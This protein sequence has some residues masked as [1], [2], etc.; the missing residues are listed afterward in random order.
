MAT[1]SSSAGPQDAR[2]APPAPAA[3]AAIAS[4]GVAARHDPFVC[5][6]DGPGPTSLVPLLRAALELVER[7]GAL[8]PILSRHVEAV[9]H[10]A[11]HALEAQSDVA[12]LGD[13]LDRALEQFPSE[14]DLS[15]AGATALAREIEAL[16]ARI[17]RDGSAI[18]LGP[19]ALVDLVT[20]VVRQARAPAHAGFV[21]QAA[22][23]AGQITGLLEADRRH[24]PAGRG[25]AAL[26]STF[27]AAGAQ[28]LDAEA[29]ARNLPEHRG[30]KRLEPDR[31]ERLE[32]TLAQLRA[33]V[34][35]TPDGWEPR[36]AEGLAGAIALFDE[37]ARAAL[38][39]LRAM[40][41]ARLEVR[42]EYD[43][44]AHDAPLARLDW[45]GL[46]A[47]ELLVVPPVVVFEE[48][49][50]VRGH[51]LSALSALLLSGR[52]IR[53]IVADPLADADATPAPDTPAGYHPGLGYLAVAHRES[54]V[55]QSTLGRPGHLI[56]GLR[57]MAT[58]HGPAA[59]FVAVP[60]WDS[61]VAPWLQLAAAREGRG[62]PCFAYDPAGGTSWAERF[63]LTDNPEIDRAW[64][65]QTVRYRD[66]SGE[67]RTLEESFTWAHAAALDPSWSAHFRIVPRA[68]WCEEQV[69]V[70]TYLDTPDDARRKLVPF[71]WTVDSE[72]H[73]CRATITRALAFACADRMRAW[74]ILQE[75]A[76]TDNEHVRRAVS[77][78]RDE[79]AAEA[80][81]ERERLESEHAAE[82]ERVRAE[83]A[84]ET[85][86]RLAAVLLGLD[87]LPRAAVDTA[88]QAAL[89]APAA[90]PATAAPQPA[91]AGPVPAEPW[92]DSALCTTCNECTNLNGRMF[93]YNANK[94]AYLADQGAGTF[95]QLVRAAEKCPA[96]C[97]HPGR[98]RPGDKTAN[99]GLLARAAAFG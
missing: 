28:A 52:P 48:A 37:A 1:V 67:E 24:G 88:A 47:E 63:D 60:C 39:A 70:A 95:E 3:L 68:D 71:V 72:G 56:P 97:I 82:L 32:A 98:P 4:N 61:P 10:A 73:L 27:G 55:L 15:Q 77:Q 65:R 26:A 35:V 51:A 8:L 58:A 19:R 41:V 16:R 38:P 96:R 90:A 7:D 59:A 25:A 74:H 23:L 9:A 54:F 64:P 6:P 13:A 2:P 12:P 79:A 93:R 45:R 42:G 49:R 69:E 43:P 92:L 21:A 80:A 17:P 78:A 18:R 31:R 94:Q 66:E 89:V 53:V 20:T 29:L 81:R 22:E 44:G 99:P 40:R 62:T 84:G 36:I 83:T 87:T 57:R 14:L 33:I 85:M 75:L 76:G 34:D 5:A 50:V 30:S 11:D 86:R 91:V 46:T